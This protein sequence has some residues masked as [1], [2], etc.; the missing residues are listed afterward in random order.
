MKKKKIGNNFSWSSFGSWLLLS[1]D[2]SDFISMVDKSTDHGKF[3]VDCLIGS[4]SGWLFV[5]LS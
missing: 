5:I 3:V 1:F 4:V 2:H